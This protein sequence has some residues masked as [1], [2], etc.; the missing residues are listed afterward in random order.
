ML[1]EWLISWLIDWIADWLVDWL[2]DGLI[3]WSGDRH[4]WWEPAFTLAQP[5]RLHL[6]GLCLQQARHHHLDNNDTILKQ[7]QTQGTVLVHCYYGRSRSATVVIAF[8]MAKVQSQW[9]RKDADTNINTC[10]T[11]SPWRLPWQW[12][13]LSAPPFN[14][15]QDSWHSSGL[16]LTDII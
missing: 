13:A 1:A 5:S 4:P 14:P 7:G 2:V 9:P 11:E 16:N 6:P 15:T 10:S 8:L 12:F 3:D